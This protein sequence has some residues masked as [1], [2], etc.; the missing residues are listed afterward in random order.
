VDPSRPPL[1]LVQPHLP[2]FD[3]I[4]SFLTH[5]PF[6]FRQPPP[7]LRRP[8]QYLDSEF[9]KTQFH[10]PIPT[11]LS[12]CSRVPQGNAFD[13][14]NYL[15][16][17]CFPHLFHPRVFPVI[18]YPLPHLTSRMSSFSDSTRF[19]P[20][21]V[22]SLSHVYLS[23]PLLLRTSP[24]GCFIWTVPPSFLIDSLPGPWR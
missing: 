20:I 22:T 21:P 1:Q 23:F 14:P 19:V 6:L 9:V 4:F 3:P 15:L 13:R 8:F 17:H 10:L 12:Q 11:Q 7:P 16:N 24:L 5:N 2:L 18:F